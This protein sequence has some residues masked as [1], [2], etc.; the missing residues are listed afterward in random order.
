MPRRI[1][2]RVAIALA[3]LLLSAS[4]SP[5]KEPKPALLHV[6]AAESGTSFER[7][8]AVWG[9]VWFWRGTEHPGR[10][11]EHDA[12]REFDTPIDLSRIDPDRS[13]GRRE[14][15]LYL[16][17]PGRAWR[18][19][20][21]FRDDEGKRT[22]TL[23]E[24]GHLA[25]EVT[26]PDPGAD[27]SLRV[28][29]AGE[30]GGA[31]VLTALIEGPGS[32][33]FAFS[34]F[35]RGS[36][37]ARV[38]MGSWAEEPVVIAEKSFRVGGGTGTDLTLAVPERPEPPVR[39]TR[40]ITCVL[41]PY[42]EVA[43]DVVRIVVARP[44]AWTNWPRTFPR[45]RY[46]G[47][48]DPPETAPVPDHPGS[49]RARPRELEIG[50]YKVRLFPT[51]LRFDVNVTEDGPPDIALTAPPPVPV[52]VFLHGL[53]ADEDPPTLRW[54]QDP[55]VLKNFGVKPSADDPSRFTFPAPPGKITIAATIEER[56]HPLRY[57]RIQVVVGKEP[58]AVDLTLN[59]VSS[60]RVRFLVDGRT[61]P[62]R[63]SQYDLKLATDASE[64]DRDYER[65]VLTL[66]LDRPGPCRCEF[67]RIPGFLPPGPQDVRLAAG[68]TVD[69]EVALTPDR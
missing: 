69:L 19:V 40:T 41:P 39:V 53:A 15:C 33:K 59:P 35:P 62:W 24:G 22:L 61:V 11:E 54:G 48:V 7:V 12:H 21:F 43:P 17:A 64:L 52:T 50:R 66:F 10:I 65:G 20:D 26:G 68:E 58:K 25:V 49:Y 42:W 67:P 57:G 1:R 6:V 16:R 27:V 44:G 37:R 4:V 9:G 63:T 14:Q 31:P 56:E 5:A 60:L 47:D 8:E 28:Y 18:R 46:G 30:E 45:G 13:F 38:E 32:H 2:A 36:F 55:K 51:G 29:R 3:L 34:G 23:R